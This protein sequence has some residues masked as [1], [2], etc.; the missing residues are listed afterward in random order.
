MDLASLDAPP[1]LLAVPDDGIRETLH[2]LLEDEGYE[3]HSVAT[4]AEA[5]VKVEEIAFALVLADLYTG[6]SPYSFTPGHVLRRRVAP[7]PLALLIMP[8]LAAEMVEW[9]GFAFAVTM[10]FELDALLSRIAIAL[11]RPLTPLQRRQA[12][13]VASYLDAV[14][15]QD[16]QTALAL[17]IDAVVYHP[18]RDSLVT[19]VRTLQ[20]VE[21]QRAYIEGLAHFYRQ[22]HIA[23]LRVYARPH[24]LVARYTG[25]W[26][27]RSGVRKRAAGTGFFR[28]EGERISQIGM[29][30]YLLRM[31][32]ER[33]DLSS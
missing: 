14:G 29:R 3:V 11:D 28:F 6:H 5:L 8:P 18:V 32:A 17:C 12:E 22:T 1:V 24:G 27:T 25:L 23:H 33:R 31:R 26:E 19:G 7:C 9:A 4:L 10:P 2:V 16:W 21:A 30:G 20:G 13:I 15:A